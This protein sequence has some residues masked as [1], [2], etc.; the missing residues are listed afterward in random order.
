MPDVLAFDTATSFVSCCVWRD[1]VVLAERRS[2]EVRAAQG[3]LLLVEELLEESGVLRKQLDA[4]GVGIGPG[5]FTGLRIGIATARGLAL[6]LGVPVGGMGTLDALLA[7]C[8]G[9]TAVID[10]R[11]GEVFVAGPGREPGVVA[12]ADLAAQLEP[13]AVLV[14]DGA[15][16]HR[17]TFWGASIAPDESP[18]HAPSAAAIAGL[19]GSL[20]PVE[21]RYLRRPDAEAVA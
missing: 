7:G 8:P 11:R 6:G 13:G 4:V 12:P 15:V 5:S 3:V 20:E 2:R 16:R 21:A 19:A 17:E 10:A 1:G 9:A 14:G 18:Q